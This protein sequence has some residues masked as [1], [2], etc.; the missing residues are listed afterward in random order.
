MN[1]RPRSNWW[2]VLVSV[3]VS[4]HSEGT[5]VRSSLESGRA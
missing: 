4:N 1:P 5:T 2:N 3:C